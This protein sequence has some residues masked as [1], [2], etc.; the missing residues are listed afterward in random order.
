MGAGR[1]HVQDGTRAVN[2]V[3]LAAAAPAPPPS[4]VGL[5]GVEVKFVL[6]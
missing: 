5:D 6:M 1:T 2:D 3:A 4:L